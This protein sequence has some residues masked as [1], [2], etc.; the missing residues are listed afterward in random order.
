[1]GVGEGEELT[2]HKAARMRRHEVEKASF[3]F[4]VAEGFQCVEMHRGNV[5]GVEIRATFSD[6]SSAR[7]GPAAYI[8][9]AKPTSRP[10]GYHAATRNLAE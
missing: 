7:L 1:M 3:R 6:S 10:V 4:R 9:V 8:L 5:H 2:R